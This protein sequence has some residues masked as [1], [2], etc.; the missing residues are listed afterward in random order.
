MPAYRV[1]PVAGTTSDG[2]L[3]DGI[4]LLAVDNLP[5]ELPNELVIFQ[6]PAEAVRAGSDRCRLRHKP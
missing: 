6:Q 1:N 5:C 2:H 3:G 4:V